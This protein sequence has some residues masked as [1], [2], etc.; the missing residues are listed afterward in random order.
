M[1]GQVCD[2]DAFDDAGVT[3]HAEDF[4]E[5]PH[6]AFWV[7]VEDFGLCVGIDFAAAVEIFQELDFIAKFCGAFE[8]ELFGSIEHFLAHLSEEFFST[9]FEERLEAS[10]V[11]SIVFFADSEVARSRAL[12][13][14]GQ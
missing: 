11:A 10:N 7:D 6:T 5:T 8:V 12:L 9:F 1:A 14:G 2:I 3:I 4:A 13:D